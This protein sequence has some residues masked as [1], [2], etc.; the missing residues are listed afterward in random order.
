[1][2]S[3]PCTEDVHHLLRMSCLLG[4]DAAHLVEGLPS[5]HEAQAPHTTCGGVS[6][7]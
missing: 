3:A 1:M 4:W 5:M 6:E 2:V 7:S